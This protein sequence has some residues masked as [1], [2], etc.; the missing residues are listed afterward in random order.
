[1][2]LLT[3]ATGFTGQAVLAALRSAIPPEQIAVLVRKPAH[4][5]VTD[6]GMLRLE[7]NL[8][9]L[10][11]FAPQL[12]GLTAIVHLASKQIDTDGK[13]FEKVNEKGTANVIQLAKKLNVK[14]VIYL[15]STG[16]YGHGSFTGA[17]EHTPLQ[18]DTPLSQSKSKA[19]QLVLKGVAEGIVLRPRFV[20]GAGD[21][22]V[23]PRF[24]KAA[25]KLP[26]LIRKGQ[27]RLS[28]IEVE[29]LADIILKMIKL[30]ALPPAHTPFVYHL[31]NGDPVS[32]K[33]LL[34]HISTELGI[35]KKRLNLPL[36]PLLALVQLREAL[37]N[38]DPESAKGGSLS[39]LRL[40][41]I[42]QDNAFSNRKLRELFPQLEFTPIE[43]SIRKWHQWKEGSPPDQ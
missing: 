36:Q 32:I 10:G 19:E 21:R 14:R 34:G 3:G 26:F 37:F 29:D 18:P 31:N 17:D 33:S 13:G 8:G 7:G 38:I 24:Q 11:S 25:E 40:K 41:F 23:L 5:L 6:P 4:R 2:I 39:S 27:A 22:H 28:F 1:M 20:I 15:S 16:V 35:E 42:S 30:P 9:D 43:E 12:T